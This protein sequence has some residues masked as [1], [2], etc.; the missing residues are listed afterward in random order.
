[1]FS[2]DRQNSSQYNI[3]SMPF[4]GDNVF[5]YF[6]KMQ[7][8]NKYIVWFSLYKEQFLK[9]VWRWKTSLTFPKK[10]AR[11]K[12]PKRKSRILQGLRVNK[13]LGIKKPN[14]INMQIFRTPRSPTCSLSFFYV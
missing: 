7:E 11:K 8:Q 13:N 4:D 10:P 14:I 5:H 3:T 1:M 9:I 12:G 2:C 6:H